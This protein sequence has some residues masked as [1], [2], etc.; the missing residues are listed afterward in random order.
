MDN[1]TI[2]MVY[3]DDKPEPALSEFLDKYINPMCDIQ[4]EED[5]T[6]NPDVDEY[7]D[8]IQNPTV[9]G[10]NIIIIDSMLFE[11]RNQ[12]NK[13]TG[14]E[15]KLVLR[16]QF[17][18]IEVIVV[19]QKYNNDEIDIVPKY[20]S[21]KNKERTPAAYYK[22]ILTPILDQAVHKIVDFRK[23]ENKIKDN[24]S[25]EK[26]LIEKTT[27]SLNGVSNY[28]DLTK[29]DIDKIVKMFQEIQ[30]AINER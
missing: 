20:A 27:D 4:S 11:N 8:L 30:E 5:I 2:K 28:D 3:I 1:K 13:L 23:I 22:N 12:T 10:A 19:T 26:V 9:T 21:R 6:F 18:F 17:P 16:K 14:E 25:I 15:F 29:S 7:N 24:V